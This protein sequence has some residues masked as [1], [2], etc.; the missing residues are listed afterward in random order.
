[1]P[2]TATERPN[3]GQYRLLIGGASSSQEAPRDGT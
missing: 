3:W 1:V 2:D